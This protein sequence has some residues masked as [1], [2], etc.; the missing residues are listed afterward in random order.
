MNAYG[1][2]FEINDNVEYNDNKCNNGID[3]NNDDNDNGC[4]NDDDDDNKVDEERTMLTMM[5]IMINISSMAIVM[6]I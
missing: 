4:I 3:T 6:M 1:S 2:I 5:S